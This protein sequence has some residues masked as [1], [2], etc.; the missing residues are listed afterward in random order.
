MTH[1]TSL[2]LLHRL[3]GRSVQTDWSR[4]V[5]LYEPLVRSWLRQKNVG[6]HDADDLVQN[7]MAVV[8][9][10]IGDFEHNGRPGAFRTWLR[11]IMLN[12]LKESWRARKGNPHAIGGSEIF[13]LISELED[14]ESHL[15]RQWNAEHDRHVMRQ[16]LAELKDQFEPR[17]WQAFEGFALQGRSAAEVAG[18]LGITS[19]AVFIAKS[20]VLA[21]LRQESEGLLD[22]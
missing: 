13:A 18:E 19:N 3:R 17:T 21:R 14:P 12:C 4:F 2:S 16:L 22:E 9:R 6:E 1:A 7:I 11:T 15:S 8:L 20:R 5:G 10:R